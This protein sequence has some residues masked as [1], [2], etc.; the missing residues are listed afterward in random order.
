MLD[1]ISKHILP[2]RQDIDWGYHVPYMLTGI[3]DLHPREAIEW[4][5]GDDKDNLVAF[6]KHLEVDLE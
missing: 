4:M 3:R 5:Q 6:Y 1:C 2:L